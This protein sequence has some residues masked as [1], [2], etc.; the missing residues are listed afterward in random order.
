MRE[1]KRERPAAGAARGGRVLG[2]CPSGA[3]LASAAAGSA[4][5]PAMPAYLRGSVTGRGP[6]NCSPMPSRRTPSRH[7]PSPAPSP[8]TTSVSPSPFQRSYSADHRPPTHH[9][10]VATTRLPRRRPTSTPR[11]KFLPSTRP[12]KPQKLLNTPASVPRTHNIPRSSSAP[13]GRTSTLSNTQRHK[14]STPRTTR[15]LSPFGRSHSHPS[16]TS[17]PS[18]R[19]NIPFSPF[20]R[21]PDD[22]PTAKPRSRALSTPSHPLENSRRGSS[23]PADPLLPRNPLS[24]GA[25]VFSGHRQFPPAHKTSNRGNT[26]LYAHARTPRT[27]L[28]RQL[29]NASTKAADPNSVSRVFSVKNSRYQYCAVFTDSLK[30]HQPPVVPAAKPS[31]RGGK[32]KK[33]NGS[34]RGLHTRG[35]TTARGRRTSMERLLRADVS[36]VSPLVLPKPRMAAP[37]FT[38]DEEQPEAS[39]ESLSLLRDITAWFHEPLAGVGA[40]GNS[41]NAEEIGDRETVFKR[42]PEKA[43]IAEECSD[44]ERCA[45]DTFDI[46]MIEDTIDGI[47]CKRG[48]IKFDSDTERDGL[49][50]A[51]DAIDE[52]ISMVESSQAGAQD[53]RC[54]DDGTS[55]EKGGTR[56][57]LTDHW[58][59][60]HLAEH[61]RAEVSPTSSFGD[62]DLTG[63]PLVSEERGENTPTS[64]PAFSTCPRATDGVQ[65]EEL[66]TIASPVAGRSWHITT[67]RPYPTSPSSKAGE[68][69]KSNASAEMRAE[70]EFLMQDIRRQAELRKS[71]DAHLASVSC[72]D[73]PPAENGAECARDADGRT[74]PRNADSCV[75]ELG[76]VPQKKH[77]GNEAAQHEASKPETGA[78]SVSMAVE[79]TLDKV[80]KTARQ[81]ASLP[82][83]NLALLLLNTCSELVS[84]VS[85][86][87]AQIDYEKVSDA[88]RGLAVPQPVP[89]VRISRSSEGST[90]ETVS[91]L[92]ESIDANVSR[93]GV[94]SPAAF[95]PPFN[96]DLIPSPVCS[97]QRTPPRPP[98][99]QAEH[100]DSPGKPCFESQKNTP[101]KPPLSPASGSQQPKNPDA[102]E[103]SA[104]LQDPAFLFPALS[105]PLLDVLPTIP[106]ALS[107]QEALDQAQ[108]SSKPTEDPTPKQKQTKEASDEPRHVSGVRLSPPPPAASEGRSAGDESLEHCSSPAIKLQAA[109]SAGSSPSPIKCSQASGTVDCRAEPAFPWGQQVVADNLDS[110]DDCETFIG[111]PSQQSQPTT[112]AVVVPIGE[113]TRDEMHISLNLTETLLDRP[114]RRRTGLWPSDG[115]SVAVV[116]ADPPPVSRGAVAAP[117]SG[118][119]LRTA[120][121]ADPGTSAFEPTSSGGRRPKRVG[122]AA[123]GC[124]KRNLRCLHQR[125]DAVPRFLESPLGAPVVGVPFGVVTSQ[126]SPSA[127]SRSSPATSVDVFLFDQGGQTP[128]PGSMFPSFLDFESQ[129]RNPEDTPFH[130]TKD[131][132]S[133]LGFESDQ[134]TRERDDE[135]RGSSAQNTDETSMH[136]SVLTNDVRNIGECQEKGTA[137][138]KQSELS[139]SAGKRTDTYEDDREQE[140]TEATGQR[141][142][143]EHQTPYRSASEAA[144]GYLLCGSTSFAR[145]LEGRLSDHSCHDSDHSSATSADTEA[146][147]ELLALPRRSCSSRQSRNE[148]SP[149]GGEKHSPGARLGPGISPRQRCSSDSRR[150]E[151][152]STTHSNSPEV[153]TPEP[154]TLKDDHLATETCHPRGGTSVLQLPSSEHNPDDLSGGS[155]YLSVTVQEGQISRTERS[156]G[157]GISAL[158]G[159]TS[160]PLRSSE[161]SANGH[162]HLDTTGEK[163]CLLVN[164]RSSTGATERLPLADSARLAGIR[165]SV[166]AG[167]DRAHLPSGRQSS[168]SQ[169]RRACFG[170]GGKESHVKAVSDIASASAKNE[171]IVHLRPSHQGGLSAPL[172]QGR[173]PL[174][175]I[176]SLTGNTSNAGPRCAVSQSPQSPFHFGGVS[177]S[178]LTLSPVTPASLASHPFSVLRSPHQHTPAATSDVR[179]FL[180]VYQ[181]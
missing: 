145:L 72:D 1:G 128:S 81:I 75:D 5:C 112:T 12:V 45:S 56:C 60:A 61:T 34:A 122:A 105:N 166:R 90:V 170:S 32:G 157:D 150:P 143:E 99:R 131:S 165:H 101:V 80:G 147:I 21:V 2:R 139:S 144:S 102:A 59:P 114:K 26:P 44:G 168:V 20:R 73:R 76:R 16:Q 71:R 57:Q 116:A 153:F 140:S 15:S 167:D 146:S 85:L 6:R 123:G 95:L 113:V 23:I 176:Q 161:S 68:D 50:D 10:P 42:D 62:T 156:C 158:S 164:I 69:S 179:K 88:L 94:S 120:P 17:T 141:K 41:A 70:V 49:A 127:V 18:R 25:A 40:S 53:K 118:G 134:K 119:A 126:T 52:K 30:G 83:A 152:S 7:V 8:Q 91:T 130:E 46:S 67:S 148:H 24:R 86:S 29:S 36:P 64:S 181:H 3:S 109:M 160:D 9:A 65:S 43:D 33:E 133:L 174:S 47:A 142:S 28:A 79:Q 19:Q 106:A 180:S 169:K 171:T 22:L 89:G 98:N 54:A 92:S 87:G 97:L 149:A 117:S 107:G 55:E 13:F 93:F 82:D 111:V 154:Q 121:V 104:V 4:K 48:I 11:H 38:R 63:D 14:S 108:E 173:T 103:R 135:R 129:L 124:L 77:L 78:A 155:A 175:T 177:V 84:S 136:A 110:S 39:H 100:N 58:D 132:N 151:E 163:R 178:T 35:C 66:G 37:M 159:M 27:P 74:R 115:A 31:A 137:E 51:L 172:K 96:T 138:E 125:P 162:V